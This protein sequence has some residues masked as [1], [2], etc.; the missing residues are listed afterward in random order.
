MVDNSENAH[1]HSVP[2]CMVAKAVRCIKIS[3]LSKYDFL[4][5]VV[6]DIGYN[7]QFLLKYKPEISNVLY[8]EFGDHCETKFFKPTFSYTSS[9]RKTSCP[10]LPEWVG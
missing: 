5:G 10:E 4:H 8:F 7:E 3:N 6:I 9:T 2:V 1:L